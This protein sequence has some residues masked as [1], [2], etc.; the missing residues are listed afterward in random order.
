[1]KSLNNNVLDQKKSMVRKKLN[2]KFP[3]VNAKN[4]PYKAHLKLKGGR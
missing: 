4:N 3:E 2:N 1:M